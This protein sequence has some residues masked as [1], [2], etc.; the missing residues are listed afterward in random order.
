MFLPWSLLGRAPESPKQPRS[1]RTQSPALLSKKRKQPLLME[2]LEDRTLLAT[3][4]VDIT[5]P[6]PGNDGLSAVNLGTGTLLDPYINIQAAIRRAN[7]NAGHDD[8]IIFGNNTNNPAMVYTWD[9]D[10]DKDFDGLPDGNMTISTNGIAGNTLNVTFLAQ[11]SA[12]APAP[13][14]VKMLNNIVDVGDGC[15]LRV[16]GNSTYRVIFTSLPDDSAG[17]DTNAD[18][19]I[20]AP[21]RADWG[22]IRY[23]SGAVGQGLN[24]PALGS[25]INWADIRYTGQTLFDPSVLDNTEFAGVRMEADINSGQRVAVRVWNTI[26]RHG[27]RAID[28]NI[29]SLAGRGPDLGYNASGAGG[30]GAQP[31]T[32]QN[33]S[34]NGAFI[35]IPFITNPFNPRFG[36]VI[37]L[38]QD[39][40]LDDVG[41]PYV[42]TQRFVLANNVTLTIDPAIIVKLQRV[43]IDTKDAADVTDSTSG[44]LIVNG[45]PER[46]V[47]FTSIADDNVFIPNTILNQFYNNGSADT[48]NDGNLTTPQ[49]GDWAGIRVSQ[50]NIDHAVIR[51]GGGLYPLQGTFVNS[52]A[53][54]IFSQD[55][56]GVGGVIETFR[57]S[58]SE[59]T[60]TFTGFVFGTFYDSPAIDVFSR[61]WNPNIQ[62]TGDISIIDNYIHHNQGKAAQAHPMAFHDR[63]NPTG[64]YGVNFRR[65]IIEQN[66]NNSVYI[67]FILDLARGIDQ[68][69]SR[70]GGYFD[71]SDIV[72]T[73]DGQLL[74]VHSDQ[75]FQIM[76]RRGVEPSP[77]NG[78]FLDRFQRSQTQT[79]NQALQAFLNG[80]VMRLPGIPNIPLERGPIAP[81]ANPNL[82]DSGLFYYLLNFEDTARG[83]GLAANPQS[84]PGNLYGEE[85]RDW[86]INLTTGAI[87]SLKPFYVRGDIPADSDPLG[88]PVSGSNMLAVA[89]P[90]GNGS[91]DMTF[92]NAVSAVGFWLIGNNTTSPNERIEFIGVDGNLIE[93]IA[94][95]TVTPGNNRAFIGRISKQPIWKI[96]IIEDA[97]DNVGGTFNYT[98]PSVI[99]PD[100]G[101]ISATLNVGS[102]FTISDLN[103][104]L[105]IVHPRVSDLRVQ[106]RGP[107][108]TTIDLVNRTPA[109]LATG[110]DFNNTYFD[111]QSAYS[112][113]FGI[114]PYTA[115]FK[116][117]Q[118]LSAF[119]GK[120][121]LGNWQVIVTDL[122]A[123][124]GG[125]AYL[126][127]FSL[128]FQSPSLARDTIAIDDLYYVEAPQ[129]LVLKSASIG[130]T[131]TAG[132]VASGYANVT[133]DATGVINNG[134]IH[135]GRAITVT[136]TG[137]Q[138]RGVGNGGTIRILGQYD[139][140]VILTSLFDNSV[141]AGTVGH[142]QKLTTNDPF[143]LP[144]PGD[145]RGI[146]I[147]QG[148][149][150]SKSFVETQQA[151]GSINRR[152]ADLNPY[153]LGDEGPTYLPGTESYMDQ[154]MP[155]GLLD[156][157]PNATQTRVMIQDGVLIEHADIRY[158]LVG[159]DHVG[160]PE[161]KITIDANELEQNET[162]RRNP[163]GSRYDAPTNR[164]NP[165]G[166]IIVNDA[167]QVRF[168]TTSGAY[169][170]GAR[171]GGTSENALT[172]TDDIDWFELPH[173][174]DYG[175]NSI[176]FYI[177]VQRGNATSD[178]P[179]GP[180]G[181]AVFNSGLQLL[182]ISYSGLANVAGNIVGATAGQLANS[183]NAL[184]GITALAGDIP[185]TLANPQYDAHFVAIFPSGRFPRLF[186]PQ[187]NGGQLSTGQRVALAPLPGTGPVGSN[188]FRVV[189]IIDQ[190]GNPQEIPSTNQNQFIDNPGPDGAFL[191]GY[192]VEFRNSGFTDRSARPIRAAEGEFIY[193]Q[194]VIQESL[195]AGLT[196]RDRRQDRP[197]N[198]NQ[199]ATIP[200]Q[201]ARFAQDNSN[202]VI[203][204]NGVAF[205]NLDYF[206]PGILVSNN[207]F[208]NNRSVGVSLQEDN[209]LPGA[210]LTT[211]TNYTT[212]INNTFDG[213]GGTAIDLRTRGGVNVLNN[214][215]SNNAIG[216]NITKLPDIEPLRPPI[217]AVVAYNLFFQN[218]THITPSSVLNGSNNLL[219]V[220]PLYVD[221]QGFDYRLLVASPAV[222]SAISNVSDRLAATRF[223]QEPTRAPADDLRGRAR[224]DNTTRPNVGAGQF[225][226]YDR[227]AFEATEPPLR[228]IG[229]N[230]VS[231]NQ[232][233]G[234]PVTQLVITF[235]GR[236]DVS[237]V[238][239][240]TVRLQSGS[241]SGPLIGL[242]PITQTYD[243]IT[244]K[245]VFVV[246]LQQSLI[247]GVYCLTLK[248]TSTG[249]SD[250]GIRDISGNLL[251][252]EFPPPYTFPS[253][254]G[255]S[256][257]SL[258]YSF[259]VRTASVSGLVWNNANGN[260]TQ[261]PG[262]IG[263]AN[264]A[265]QLTWAGPDGVFGTADDGAPVNVNTNLSG[266]FTFT[267]LQPGNYR[268]DVQD[269]TL[270]ANFYL[271]TPPDPRFITV[272]FGENLTGINFGYWQDFSNATLGN[273]AW[274]DLNGDGIRQASE[275]VMA[276]IIIN[277][278]WAGR[279]G[280]FG[281]ADDQVFTTTSD[282]INGGNWRFQ[283]ILPAGNYQV[284]VDMSS[285]PA[286][287]QR[288]T[289]LGAGQYPV[290]KTPLLPGEQFNAIQFGFQQ[291][292]AAIGDTVFNDL[293][294][295]G[296]QDAGE[297]GLANIQV[298]LNGPGGTQNVLTDV[299]GNY[300]FS[301][302]AAGTY[303]V[304]VNTATLPANFYNTT[305]NPLTINLPN[306]VTI[307]NT[308]D[309]GFRADPF[310]GVIG[311]LVWDD[312]NGNGVQDGG[313]L[314]LPNVQ[315]VA[316]WA[317]RDGV[318]GTGDDQNFS[319]LTNGSGIYTLTGLPIGLYRVNTGT[320]VPPGYGRTFPAIVP[321]PVTIGDGIG[322]N[323][324]PNFLNANFGFQLANATIG[325]VVF[326]D[327]NGNGILDAVPNETGRFSNVRV[328][329]DA[330][331]N[332]AWD[333]GELFAVS[334]PGTGAWSI[335]GLA[336]GTYK[337]MIDP[338][339]IP[340]TPPGLVASPAFINVNVPPGGNVTGQNL[341]LWQR[342]STVSG[343]VFND[344]NLN[345]TIDFGEQGL[346]G[347]FV[348]LI[349]YG[350]NN[351]F[352]NGGGDDQ[353]FTAFTD[354]AGNYN[355]T[356]L[357]GS[358]VAG[359]NY[360]IFVDTNTV[361]PG[362][363]PTIPNPPL[364]DFN[365]PANSNR[366][367]NFGFLVPPS[368]LPGIYY[369]SV[370]GVNS[371]QNS[372]GSLTLVNDS[373][374]V[375]LHTQPNGDYRYDVYF[376]GS[377]FGLTP[378]T[379]AIDAFTI[380][381][382][383]SILISTTGSMAVFTT[384]AG[385]NAGSGVVQSGF[386]EDI[387]RFVPT[388]FNGG[389]ISA[390]NW[391]LTFRGSR[392]GLSGTR[393]NVIAVAALY[394][395]LNQVDRLLLSTAGQVTVSGVTANNFDVIQFS[396]ISFGPNTNGIFY[397]YLRGTNVGLNDQINENIDG[398]NVVQPASGWPT[399]QLSTSGSFSVPG[400]SGGRSDLFQFNPTTYGNNTAGTWGPTLLLGDNV[401]LTNANITDFFVGQAPGDPSP[402]YAAGAAKGK[403]ADL[404]SQV[405]RWATTTTSVNVFVDQS[406]LSPDQVDRVRDAMNQINGLWQ[407]ASGM[408]LVEVANETNADIVIRMKDSSSL[409]DIAKGLLGQ[410]NFVYDTA[411]AG[412]LADGRLYRTFISH[413]NGG[414]ASVDLIGGWNWYAGANANSIGRNQYDFQSVVT[415]ELGHLLGL[416]ENRIDP[417]QVMFE[418]LRPG[419][420]RRV[421]GFADASNLMRLYN[422]QRT[423][424]IAG[425][426]QLD[427]STLNQLANLVI[428]PTV[429]R[430][431]SDRI[432]NLVRD[433][434]MP[435][436][437]RDGQDR[438]KQVADFVFTRASASSQAAAV[439]ADLMHQPATNLPTPNT[440]G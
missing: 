19:N 88:P 269:N 215:I 387:F 13:L 384:Y 37:Q 74:A 275:P 287:F 371:L 16:E 377:N 264:V 366:N 281:T 392:V 121:S 212:I 270:P 107:D 429:S 146:Q 157:I 190:D 76:S 115:S 219:N 56:T 20:N 69:I 125:T 374:I 188:G 105:N 41:V 278:L 251:D 362:A 341:G 170:V 101:Q 201:T 254:N 224:V 239:S 52:P 289:Y 34:I 381:R 422:E 14:I 210:N 204:T 282:F 171:M 43:T 390:G 57:I 263:L 410:V 430:M 411:L 232:L 72:H 397:M 126:Q 311:S 347:A 413:E 283:N 118:A 110:A 380:L 297:P 414:K 385:P 114:A 428:P 26:I 138:A 241:F 262:E 335:T 321:I 108:G 102:N 373:D 73:L 350:T 292:S 149:N 225:P 10:A 434:T 36:Q 48:N 18:G 133:Q 351:V 80:L 155:N 63:R 208:V 261:D 306:G 331:N 61:D 402:L 175:Q 322:G 44:R 144:S 192:E 440:M 119:N 388:A 407:Q 298:I 174:E 169:R 81:N 131:L 255:I 83:L 356:N 189:S 27:G 327:L 179:G 399:L 47:L 60:Q 300:T 6:N 340:G 243:P 99:I 348:T 361:P 218:S 148:A 164:I 355:F 103:V 257:G 46:P 97:M 367:Q 266:N 329:I 393:G 274:N 136:G 147:S 90:N 439:L 109:P 93:S 1:K 122:A 173:P 345:G 369:L 221:R 135:D 309:F 166:A 316:T 153:T 86:G 66:A 412:N 117:V 24:N 260:L 187:P 360:R 12:G 124:P 140:P 49:P 30:L 415:H 357:P 280:A 35:S 378:G 296:V 64:G 423:A 394:N 313:E 38:D 359:N 285:V 206:I 59:I 435:L 112:I 305:P 233:L 418:S 344:A 161:N 181:I 259:S 424:P 353:T 151:N 291:K 71:D 391:N 165:L 286:G 382:D 11:T 246:P 279:D 5:N 389:T 222:D 205:N 111:D 310:L 178:G 271:N 3:Y 68:N 182:W 249:A 318:F 203:N 145:W 288:T 337:V 137:N 180:F 240:S 128:T 123:G 405:I 386:G 142:V 172:G 314:G 376:R 160:F 234:Q 67:K 116:P 25:I 365:L 370:S 295:N 308:A 438:S 304:S 158:A 230:V 8:I 256:G 120:S 312:N 417:T 343:R 299:N 433:L 95:P 326:Q 213:N 248:G 185:H 398:I 293:N 244:N 92:P 396:A 15:Q 419:Q 94:M 432:D 31:L 290:L 303:T 75:A 236:V 354:A 235:Y 379:E 152:Y 231:G 55:L 207:L 334:A 194:N 211:P 421:F 53:V 226:F 333:I 143:T 273:L 324:G 268:V 339:Q 408:R 372:D 209:S 238:N 17:G 328:F 79:D 325:G 197:T 409:G 420:V 195:V 383:G 237:T 130:T 186:I 78:G 336:S 406:S 176:N 33:N 62:R 332:N 162:Q 338:L 89:D 70:V 139:T 223:P 267:G 54:Q 183:G 39:A 22:G 156:L 252:G 163:N 242:G 245:H 416:P 352:E 395:S 127:D 315:V 193:R 82:V 229:L 363:T 21:N 167:G 32:F 349:W 134:L 427:G 228:V 368:L 45:L 2:L 358:F 364:V 28:V 200:S 330:N 320:G 258:L 91:F 42:L 65:N 7:A 425:S 58:N 196:I 272:N 9:R 96:R 214:I 375:K 431:Q 29:W 437:G 436:V 346:S 159:I 177:D 40:Q 403:E 217:L 4:F 302:L 98:G 141:G 404:D 23:R 250:P 113:N 132:A 342:N 191:G 426:P 198:Q 265:V 106:L 104:N 154:V 199:G 247:D 100:G 319:T 294:G 253:G 216:L 401:G 168:D 227:G 323:P 85:W 277:A 87:Q 184:G 301:N 276:G 77:A 317:G 220:N 202:L 307:N 284:T 84:N 400:L 129:S 51:Y 50:G 150:S